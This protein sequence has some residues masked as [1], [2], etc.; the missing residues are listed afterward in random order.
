MMRV[1]SCRRGFTLVELLVVI[2]IIGI[3]IMLLLPAVQ[4][5]RE[6]ARRSDC[7]NRLKQLGLAL[8]NYHQ[9]F[10]VF[11]AG[12]GGTSGECF[13]SATLTGTNCG[14]LSG[15]VPLLP[16]IDEMPLWQTMNTWNNFLPSGAINNWRW[17]PFGGYP[18]APYPKYT[19]PP[20]YPPFQ[21]HI[22]A[23]VCP[24]DG[25][26]LRVDKSVINCGKASYCFS[27]GD[28]AGWLD[29][30]ND[31]GKRGLF[32]ADIWFGIQDIPDGTSNT[33]ALSEHVVF[34][35][36]WGIN[37]VR[38]EYS[39]DISLD[40]IGQVN[41]ALLTACMG[42]ALNDMLI[43]NSGQAWIGS[44]WAFGGSPCTFFCTVLPPNAPSCGGD[45]TC[46]QERCPGVYSASSYHPGGVNILMADG[47]CRFISD[48]IDTG[49]LMLP[50][51]R[52][53]NAIPGAVTIR[54]SPYGVWGAMGS[55]AGAETKIID[56]SQL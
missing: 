21:Q 43:H 31:T 1:A 47:S 56:S 41:G 29:I 23:L 17:P 9:E 25:W 19:S 8:H 5:A 4:S 15:F 33:V 36:D 46:W 26:A 34:P 32:G 18:L 28:E 22:S 50:T 52:S 3:L 40:N 13:A 20:Y 27:V 37:Q 48:S 35:A 24:S 45:H 16:Y 14:T 30:Q 7:A 10:N 44:A 6:A 39:L 12:A 42:E 38:G 49:D 55:R 11:P 54:Q 53:Q 51:V 2:T